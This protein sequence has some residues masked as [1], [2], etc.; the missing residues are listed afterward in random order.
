MPYLTSLDV[1]NQG[2]GQRRKDVKTGA[3]YG[4]GIIAFKDVKDVKSR[5]I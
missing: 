4:M 5:H 3:F 2:K 1:K